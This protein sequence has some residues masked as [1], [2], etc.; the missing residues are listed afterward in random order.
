MV[1]DGADDSLT[2]VLDFATALDGDDFERVA[3]HLHGDV[4]YVIGGVTHRGPDAVVES[5]RQG[6]ATA[7]RIFDQV[8]FTHSIVSRDNDT[9]RVDFSD[10]LTAGGE[11]FDHHSVQDITVDRHR[12][13]T[14]IVDQ[15]VDGQRTRLDEFMSRHA[16]RR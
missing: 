5:Y 14:R 16:R 12:L 1:V 11:A 8:E 4:V 15:P 6:S 7:R 13:V 2:T 9:F 10:R 3:R